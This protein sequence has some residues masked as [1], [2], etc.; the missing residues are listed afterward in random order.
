MDILEEL[1]IHVDALANVVE[2]D[3][4]FF[5]SIISY[6][7]R[8]KD[9]IGDPNKSFSKAE[10][11]LLTKKI[12]EFYA[13]YRPDLVGFYIPPAQTS[14]S[15][16][17]V[18]EINKVVTK[19]INLDDDSFE[20]L[21]ASKI[22]SRSS[23]EQRTRKTSSHQY[24][25]IGHGRSK[26]WA[27]LKIF[28]EDE[29]GL[30]TITY[31]SE[32]RTGESIVPILDNLLEQATFAILILTAEDKT[33]SGSKRA[34]QNVVHEAGL[35][36]GR[37]GFKKAVILRQDGLDDFT[38]VAGLQHIGFSGEQIEQSFYEVQRVLKREGIS[39]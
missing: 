22:A 23:I 27:R 39:S 24:I 13:N 15:D 2:Q 14:N 35:F 16:S 11:N 6:V 4:K 34:R 9:I 37:L 10:L 5:A 7:K 8:L 28:L 31:E 36:Q 12:E 30:K 17:T 20:S 19:I 29:L 18:K 38:N 32:S 26:L 1:K 25:F 3:S 21:F 33:A